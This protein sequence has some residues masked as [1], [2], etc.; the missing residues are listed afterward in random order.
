MST[1]V[2]SRYYVEVFATNKAGLVGSASGQ[3]LL[4]LGDADGLSI[5]GLTFV[6]AGSIIAVALLIFLIGYLFFRRR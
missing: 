2:G 3:P 5:V 1:Q 4:I 6:V